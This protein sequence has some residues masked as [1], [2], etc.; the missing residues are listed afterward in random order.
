M[1]MYVGAPYVEKN[2]I[3]A[4]LVPLKL[5]MAKKSN[6]TKFVYVFKIHIL[7]SNCQISMQTLMDVYIGQPHLENISKVAYLEPS[8][9]HIVKQA[10]LTFVIF[11]SW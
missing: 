5:N 8:Q 4:W 2:Y 3:G 7:K 9:L 6:F 1:D 11:I 10:R